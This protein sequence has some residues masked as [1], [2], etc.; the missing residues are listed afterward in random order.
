MFHLEDNQVS[1]RPSSYSAQPPPAM[2]LPSGHVLWSGMWQHLL[3]ADSSEVTL[4]DSG[5]SK[6]IIGVFE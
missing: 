4:D 3:S 2:M 5:W 1:F 6:M